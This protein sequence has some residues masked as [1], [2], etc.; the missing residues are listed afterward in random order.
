MKRGRHPGFQHSAETLA[1][2]GA[3]VARGRWLADAPAR[4]A[5]A[6]EV[7]HC[8]AFRC[9]CG[10]EVVTTVGPELC[11]HCWARRIELSMLRRAA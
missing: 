1:K 4:T 2:I 6:V 7:Q 3:G 8:A 11:S 10:A 5:A 9:R